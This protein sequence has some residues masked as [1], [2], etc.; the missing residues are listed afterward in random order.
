MFCGPG[1]MYKV[2]CAAM[3]E[4][5]VTERR[6]RHDVMAQ[7]ANVKQIPG[8]PEEQIGKTHKITVVRGIQED[9]IDARA[10]EP[11]AVALERAAIPVDTHCRGGEC[12]FCRSQLLSG[13]IFISPLNDGRRREDKEMG[14]FHACSA[15][16]VS[17]IRIKIPIL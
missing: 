8:F 11:V 17:D 7:P 15:Y 9:V 12:G 16:P 3:Q 6:F 14:W 4:M 10:D 1:A 2:I 13:D 5:G